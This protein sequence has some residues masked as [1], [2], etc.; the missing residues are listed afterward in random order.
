MFPPTRQTSS[1]P[2]TRTRIE[3]KEYVMGLLDGGTTSSAPST[4]TRIETLVREWA[5]VRASLRAHHP[6]EQGLKPDL[7]QL[8]DPGHRLRAH[9]PRE[10]GL[11]LQTTFT[12]TLKKSL[13]AHHPREQ[14]LKPSGR[15]SGITWSNF[16]RTIH[17]NK[18]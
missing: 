8:D 17:E 9:H 11:K 15:S 13:R 4:R 18:D 5:S 14:G 16:E 10:Q 6:R 3:T 2:S 12:D 7:Y 1:A